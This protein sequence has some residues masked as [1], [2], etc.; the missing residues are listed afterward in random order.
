MS[1]NEDKDTPREALPPA[2]KQDN[3][4]ESEPAV[5]P[6]SY[7]EKSSGTSGTSGAKTGAL[8]FFVVLLLLA[9]I[10]LFAGA[11]WYWTQ[12]TDNTQSLVDAQRTQ[13]QEVSSLSG[14]LRELKG[15]IASLKRERSEQDQ[16]ITNLLSTNEQLVQQSE[17]V[18]QQL[19]NLEGRRPADWLIAE[20][21]YLVRMAG[22]KLWLEQ[23]IRTAIMLLVNADKRLKSL[24][25]PSVLPVRAKLAEDIQMLQQLNPVSHT[26]VA[27]ALSGMLNQVKGLPLDTFEKPAMA[28]DTTSNDVSEST[29]DWLDN[30]K[31]VWRSLVD[32]FISVKDL[33]GPIEP[34]LDQQARW[35]VKEQLR[36]QIMNAQSAALSANQALYSQSLQNAQTILIEKFDIETSQVA[37]FINALQNLV[38]TDIS[39]DIPTELASQKPLENLLDQRVKQVFGQGASAL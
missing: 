21:D 1:S 10:A 36:F 25:D 38:D 22:R 7:T 18:Q 28:G 2:D 12:R 30:L 3:A 24:S 14:E 31:A 20:A 5:T 6:D 34:V 4:P 15:E 39:R 16:K 32:D 8:W 35:L 37:G 19:E 29:A 9:V 27:L 13:Q 33:N 17:S 11:Y 23:D 26:S